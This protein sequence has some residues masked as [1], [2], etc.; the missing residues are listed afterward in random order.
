MSEQTYYQ[1]SLGVEVYPHLKMALEVVD[2][3]LPKVAVDA[4]CGAGRDALFLLERGF[5]VHAYD[6]S[7]A[8]I[9]RLREKGQLHLDRTLFPQVCSFEY[10]AYPES[11]L[12]NACS[13]LFFCYQ[14]RFAT[15]WMNIA[16]SL[17]KGGVFCGHFMGP[18]DSWVKM[19]HGDLTV[20]SK[21]ELNELFA[22]DFKI[23]DIHEHDAE[24]MTLLSKQKH[25]HTYSVVA[26]KITVVN[27]T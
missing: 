7:D 3:S 11:S 16:R 24:G 1:R 12:I 25:W 17:L 6:K 2:T 21:A 27:E 18:N 9:A 20:H 5:T 14:E 15:A 13:S 23:L 4:G 19:G 22:R 26:Q 8:A 10:F